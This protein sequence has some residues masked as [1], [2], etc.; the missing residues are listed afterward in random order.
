MQLNDVE[1]LKVPTGQE[2]VHAPFIKSYPVAHTAQTEAEA[3]LVQFEEQLE[4]KV[5][6]SL[7]VP[8]KHII[9]HE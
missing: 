2:S 6:L 1:F 9:A 5:E 3:Q 7:K 8:A 4:H